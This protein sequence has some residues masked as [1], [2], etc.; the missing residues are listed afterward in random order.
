[1]THRAIQSLRV[2]KTVTKSHDIH[3]QRRRLGALLRFAFIKYDSSSQNPG[4]AVKQ[5]SFSHPAPSKQPGTRR[6]L[7]T[8]PAEPSWRVHGG[9]SWPGGAEGLVLGSPQPHLGHSNSKCPARMKIIHL[10]QPALH[11][12][13]TDEAASKG[14][15]GKQRWREAEAAP[16]RHISGLGAG[17]CVC[18]V[19]FGKGRYQTAKQQ[20]WGSCGAA[21]GR[22]RGLLTS[23]RLRVTRQNPNL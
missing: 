7:H 6:D 23:H 20:E 4:S 19:G 13:G 14:R 8:R 12:L 2:F 18:T 10:A 16:A 21:A 17:G 11:R 22:Q 3:P 5:G 15:P 9:R 1:M